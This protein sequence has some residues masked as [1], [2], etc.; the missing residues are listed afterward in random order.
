[1]VTPIHTFTHTVYDDIGVPYR[2]RAEGE[3]H[4]DG[5]WHGWLVYESLRD[6]KAL[7]TE[8]ETTQGKWEDLE[9]WASGLEDI[10]LDGALA[11]A[12]RD[13]R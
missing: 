1:M 4:A 11:R 3:R 12:R 2:V 13:P 5:L 7:R 6:G 9:Y 8:R 10:Y